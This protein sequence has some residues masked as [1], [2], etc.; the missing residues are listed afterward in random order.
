MPSNG[1]LK[2]PESANNVD[3]PQASGQTML[4]SSTI[5]ESIAK[6]GCHWADVDDK[7]LVKGFFS[8][9]LL[10]SGIS[11]KSLPESIAS[12]SQGKMGRCGFIDSEWIF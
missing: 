4:H 1:S 7:I 5:H 8:T 9:I 11:K 12:D 6:S 3:T 10:A 2:R